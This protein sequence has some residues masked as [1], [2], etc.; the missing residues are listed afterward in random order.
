MPTIVSSSPP[1]GMHAP[2]F[3]LPGT[4]GAVHGLDS[5]RGPNGLLVMFICNHCPYVQAISDRLAADAAELHALGIGV[6]AINPNDAAQQPEDDYEHMKL[7]AKRWGL[8]FPYLHDAT[9]AVARAFGAVCTPDFYGFDRELRLAYHGRLDAAHREPRP[10]GMHRELVEAMGEI[11][12]TGRSGR[13]Q[14]PSLGCS[15]KWKS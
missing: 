6:V 4:D 8:H 9:Q 1:L 10:P 14:Q 12:E 3:S 11:A 15:I 7:Y 13:A 2:D 5:A